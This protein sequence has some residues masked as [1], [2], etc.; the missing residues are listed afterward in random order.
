MLEFLFLCLSSQ[1]KY[2]TLQGC[3]LGFFVCVLWW[4]SSPVLSTSMFFWGGVSQVLRGGIGGNRCNFIYEYRHPFL[5]NW[6]RVVY[7]YLFIWGNL[8]STSP[9][10]KLSL[11]EGKKGS[12]HYTY[13]FPS[14]GMAF[15]TNIRYYLPFIAQLSPDFLEQKDSC[16]DPQMVYYKLSRLQSVNH[17]DFVQ[18]S[19]WMLA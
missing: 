1:P 12:F 6:K 11:K 10:Y 19:V 13:C 16:L 15:Y 3:C 17:L 8:Y 14:S 7:T 18:L 5:K 4:Y 9:E 2:N